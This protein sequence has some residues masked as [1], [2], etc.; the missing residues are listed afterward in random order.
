MN[1]KVVLEAGVDPGHVFHVHVLFPVLSGG[2]GGSFSLEEGRC[3]QITG[4]S[5]HSYLETSVAKPRVFNSVG[6]TNSFFPLK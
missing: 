5:D 6:Q 1:V 4:V 3:P 2:S